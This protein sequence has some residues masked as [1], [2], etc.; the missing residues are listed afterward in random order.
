VKRLAVRA[1]AIALVAVTCYGI[2]VVR[3]VWEGR[4]ALARGDD[5]AARGDRAAAIAAWRD[6]AAW[7]APLAPHVDAAEDRLA[8]A[9]AGAPL[10]AAAPPMSLPWTCAALLGLALVGAGAVHFARRG[11]DGD[12]LVPREATGAGALVAVGL[13]LWVLGLYKA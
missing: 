12:R 13:V 1:V 7:T 4:A 9:G 3:A 6:A 2:A 8:R 5:A 10:P 11:L